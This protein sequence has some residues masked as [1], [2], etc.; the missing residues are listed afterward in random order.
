MIYRFVL[1]ITIFLY[2]TLLAVPS[3]SNFEIPPR[4]EPI[5]QFP[6][7]RFI[8]AYHYDNILAILK[9]KELSLEHRNFFEHIIP[10][11]ELGFFGYHSSTQGFRIFQDIIRLVLEETCELEIKK[12]FHF[13]RVPGKPLYSCKSSMQFLKENPYIRDDKGDQQD[14]LVSLNYALFGNFHDF[15]SCS[16]SYFTDNRSNGTIGFQDRLKEFFLEL[17][18]PQEAIPKLFEIGNPLIATE[19][20]V[21]FQFFDFS[22]HH[23]LNQ[24]YA[25]VDQLGYRALQ[26]G[27]P[28][29]PVRKMSELY[30]DDQSQPFN[31]ELRLLMTNKET[32]NPYSPLSI[33]RY[34]R[35]DPEVVKEYEIALRSSIRALPYDEAKVKLYRKKLLTAWGSNDW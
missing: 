33:K 15:G 35:T 24:P 7:E 8:A 1:F 23:A 11:E 17:G 31:K 19:N 6:T 18:L 21:L 25:L 2:S 14:Q 26:G 29:V 20:A 12:D 32:L 13:L 3:I 16:V 30:L 28:Q 27:M 10:H 4:T 34:E 5:Y 9:V 22:H